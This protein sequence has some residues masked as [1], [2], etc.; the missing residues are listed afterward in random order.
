MN[1]LPASGAGSVAIREIVECRE[2]GGAGL[3]S[4][5]VQRAQSEC[6]RRTRAVEA[7]PAPPSCWRGGQG[8]RAGEAIFAS[9]F[10]WSWKNDDA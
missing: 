2:M 10:V 3:A 5:L 4:V 6:A 9:P 1:C 8:T 7:S